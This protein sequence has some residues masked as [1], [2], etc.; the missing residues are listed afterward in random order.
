MRCNSLKSFFEMSICVYVF[1][2]QLHCKLLS[3]CSIPLAYLI[4]EDEVLQCLVAQSNKLINTLVK[5]IRDKPYTPKA[6]DA[7]MEEDGN[8]DDDDEIVDEEKIKFYFQGCEVLR[9][10]TCAYLYVHMHGIAKENVASAY[11]ILTLLFAF[12]SSLKCTKLKFKILEST[13]GSARH[14]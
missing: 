7:A 13:F 3:N 9:A 6:G 2:Y 14:F 8:D 11:L 4:E 1:N 10:C 5:G 12:N